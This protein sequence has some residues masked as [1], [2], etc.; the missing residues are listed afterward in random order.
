MCSVQFPYQTAILSIHRQRLSEFDS[1]FQP[2]PE[3]SIVNVLLGFCRIHA[4]S[5]TTQLSAQEMV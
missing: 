1:Q 2:S 5:Q 4:A 3:M